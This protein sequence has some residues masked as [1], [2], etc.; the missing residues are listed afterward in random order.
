VTR[1]DGSDPRLRQLADLHRELG[2]PAG[3][4]SERKLSP[5][6]EAAPAD[7]VDIGI[8]DEGR[9]IQLVVR[10]AEAWAH[11]RRAAMK[12]DIELVP[13]SGFRSMARQ[14]EIIRNKIV[15]G[16]PLAE[17]LRYV[18]APGFSEHHTGRAIDIGS[19]EH[20][21]LDEE[22]ARTAAFAWLEQRAREFGFTLSY[23]RD[24]PHGI[25]YEPWHWCWA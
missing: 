20:I 8:N 21:E 2:I 6:L 19:P 16:Q 10:A 25:G 23:P 15:S 3:Y 14:T 11:M 24:N 17:I 12:Q 7:L 18:A 5:F 1:P 4:A 13:I 22:F 9:P